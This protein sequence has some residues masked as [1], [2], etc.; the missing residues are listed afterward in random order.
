LSMREFRRGPIGA[1]VEYTVWILIIAI[2]VTCAVMAVSFVGKLNGP[3]HAPVVGDLV[4]A[5]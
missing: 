2:V 5:N 1:M 4:N 3:K